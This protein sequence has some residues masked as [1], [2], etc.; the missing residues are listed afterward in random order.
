MIK[1]VVKPEFDNLIGHFKIPG[2]IDD[3]SGIDVVAEH[4]NV[5]LIGLH[6]IFV[7]A[8][9]AQFFL[10]SDFVAQESGETKVY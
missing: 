3:P 1:C 10:L 6:R 2:K 9:S 5:R 4:L 7:S 8:K